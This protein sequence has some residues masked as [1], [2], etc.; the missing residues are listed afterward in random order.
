MN[1][2]IEIIIKQFVE[3]Y[4]E[5]RDVETKWKEPLVAYAD[6]MDEMFYNL[7]D[8]VSPSHAIPQ[9]FLPEAK[10]VVAYFIPF[11]EVVV[12]SNIEGKESSKVWAK[13]YVETNQLILD[14]NTFIKNEL[15]KL[16][17]KSNIMPATHNFDNEKLISDWSHRH[18][19]FIAGLGKFGLNNMLI[20]DKG[21]CGRVGSFITD[22]K[23][24]PTK[25]KNE[26]NC[27]YKHMNVCKKCVDRCVN[28]ALKVDYFDIHK[29]YEMCL[30][31]DK[32]HSDIGLSDVCGKCLVNVPCSKT[33]P[34]KINK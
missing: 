25:R 26:E 8:A 28:N 31:N 5:M 6:A 18:V 21:C 2:K 33:N 12:E 7:K 24:E 27:L 16:G 20:T 34:V 32:I 30:H 11:D 9:D 22:L 4:S 14:L 3:H 1:N 19:A 29:C 17:Y 10:T 13:A 23:I 15:Q